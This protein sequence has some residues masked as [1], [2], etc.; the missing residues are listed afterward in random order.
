MCSVAGAI[1]RTRPR[2]N[3]QRRAEPGGRC[4]APAGRDPDRAGRDEQ[5]VRARESAEPQQ[6]PPHEVRPR[7]ARRQEAPQRKKS[8]EQPGRASEELRLLRGDRSEEAEEREADQARGGSVQTA[9]DPPAEKGRCKSHQRLQDD[10]RDF[11]SVRDGVKG[12]D[13]IRIERS[14]IE[15]ALAGQVP[16]GDRAGPLD[17]GPRVRHRLP[18]NGGDRNGLKE[19]RDTGDQ[20]RRQNHEGGAVEDRTAHL[21]RGSIASVRQRTTMK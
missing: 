7:V 16:R 13:Q 12:S 5:C 1:A 11:R 6:D 15:G 19:V 18:Q 2:E 3:R 9:R 10:D 8:E 4:V 21:T 17:V 14:T 20:D